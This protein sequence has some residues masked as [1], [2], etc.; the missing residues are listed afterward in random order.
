M[1]PCEPGWGRVVYAPPLSHRTDIM[2][3]VNTTRDD[4]KIEGM[5]CRHCVDAVKGHLAALDDVIVEEVGIGHARVA[6]TTHRVTRDVLERAVEEAGFSV[7][8]VSEVG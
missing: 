1:I 7:Q 5:T 2:A 6:Y 8:S 4:L 3:T